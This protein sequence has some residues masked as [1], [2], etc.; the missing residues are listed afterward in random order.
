M[1]VFHQ[2]LRNLYFYLSIYAD[3]LISAPKIMLFFPMLPSVNK[4]SERVTN[5][6]P[7]LLYFY[8]SRSA[9]L[10]SL[11]DPNNQLFN[12]KFLFKSLDHRSS[13]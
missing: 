7:E 2:E 4:D 6:I 11:I 9:F 10:V 5:P 3:E 8:L 13:F 1:L 12:I